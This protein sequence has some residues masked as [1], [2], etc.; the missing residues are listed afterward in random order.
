MSIGVYIGCP[1]Y[2]G[3][4]H[5]S[6]TAGLMQVAAFCGK[7]GVP[8]AIDCIP[9]DAFISKARNTIVQRFLTKTDWDDLVFIDADV[10]FTLDG[11]KSLMKSE[12]EIVMGLYRVKEDRIKFPALLFEPITPNPQDP[13]LVKLQYGPAGFMRVKRKVFEAMISKWPEEYYTAGEGEGRMYDF[14]PSGRKGHHFTGED[15]NFCERAISCGFDLW[16]VQ[17]IALDHTGSKTYDAN[18]RVLRPVEEQA[19]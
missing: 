17:D 9:G 18:W 16:A 1:T 4:L 7:M 11:F 2:D 14:F 5:W 13:R 6:T 12:A 10:G 3:K 19:A 8:F 15:I